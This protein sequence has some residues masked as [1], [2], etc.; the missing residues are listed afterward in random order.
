MSTCSI[1]EKI[2]QRQLSKEGLQNIVENKDQVNVFSTGE[3]KKLF[4]TRRVDSRS[5]THDTLRCKRC[6][7]VKQLAAGSAAST[8]AFTPAHAQECQTFLNKFVEHLQGEA[9]AKNQSEA[10]AP[11]VFE[12]QSLASELPNTSYPSLPAFSRILR[13]TVSGIDRV[14]EETKVL[15]PFSILQHFLSRWAEVVSV[16]SVMNVSSSGEEADDSYG[17]ED[18]YVEQDG[19]PEEEDL[20]KCDLILDLAVKCIID[21]FAGGA[22]IATLCH[23]MTFT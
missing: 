22:T 3:L 9:A 5:D 19:C 16:L 15:R 18:E 14:V 17:D 4:S 1:E 20:N 21:G 6:A 12:L 7:S 8:R 11:Y 2:I 10:I 13:D 23:A